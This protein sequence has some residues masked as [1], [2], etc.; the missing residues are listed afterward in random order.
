MTLNDFIPTPFTLDC[1][2]TESSGSGGGRHKYRL[3]SV[4][5]HLGASLASGH[6]IAYVRAGDTS[7]DY[8]QCK[9]PGSADTIKTSKKR[10][11]FKMFN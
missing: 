7:I 10:G 6:Y 4:I 11:L 9:R 5:L 1:F 2:C 3:Y 8:F